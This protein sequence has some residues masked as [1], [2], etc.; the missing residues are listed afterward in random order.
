MY[1]FEPLNS[2][3]EDSWDQVLKQCLGSN[4]FHST[5]WR[6]ALDQAFAQLS[7]MYYLIKENGTLIG[8]LP[9]FVFKPIPGIKMLHSMPWNLFG[10]IQLIAGAEVDI[11]ALIE[12]TDKWLADA[13]HDR[14]ICEA[15]FT[16]SPVQTEEYGHRLTEIGYQKHR[17]LFTHLLKTSEDYEVLWKA[18]NKRV[19]GAVRK[20]AK[21]GVSVSDANTDA[22]L[23]AFY[24][25]YLATVTR[26]GGTPKPRSLIQFLYRSRI[27]RLAIAKR[28]GV[29]IAGLLYLHFNRTVTLWCEA[30]DPK[31]LEHRPNN[32]IFHHIIHWA[33]ERGY[34]WVD[35]GASPPEHQG[36]IAH[37]EQYK[38]QRLD[39][40]SYIKIHSRLR[41]KVWQTAEPSLRK[42][43]T[44]IQHARSIGQ[45]KQA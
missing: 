45:L 21:A 35:F 10:G 20:A 24:Q 44:W 27:G 42:L 15:F 38:A 22:E 2:Q 1:T 26:L 25:L 9:A 37:K 6:V 28:D 23:E 3:C 30:S 39:F 31:N 43:Y 16:L 7:P 18:Y 14:R 40:C 32:A 19:R 12:S 17:T 11:K 41:R 34:E 33:C 4:A 13:V 8:G 36:L 29:V 5:A